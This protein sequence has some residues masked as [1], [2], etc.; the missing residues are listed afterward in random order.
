MAKLIKSSRRSAP[1]ERMRRRGREDPPFSWHWTVWSM[2][3]F[4][5]TEMLLG[6]LVGEYI[7][8]RYVSISLAFTLQGL[9]HL[10]S[11]FVGGL[12][13]GLVSKARRTLEPAVGAALS[14]ALMFLLTVFTPFAFMRLESGKLLV[15]GLIAF[16]IALTGAS[17][18]ER[19]MGRRA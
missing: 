4:M 13:I 5:L 3:T 2:V 16:V 19:L 14:I 9:L 6:G 12:I 1:L 8:G 18:G 11:F 7:I 15:G 10:T 17:L